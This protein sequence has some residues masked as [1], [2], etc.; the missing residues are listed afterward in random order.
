[1]R[2]TLADKL[3]LA[4]GSPEAATLERSHGPFLASQYL[5]N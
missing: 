3:N 1:M 4:H 2:A 5:D